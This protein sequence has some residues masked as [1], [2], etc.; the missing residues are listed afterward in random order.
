MVRGDGTPRLELIFPYSANE[1]GCKPWG[2]D[3]TKPFCPQGYVSSQ[4]G[5]VRAAS[6]WFA[7]QIAAIKVAVADELAADVDQHKKI[8]RLTPVETLARAFSRPRSIS[9]SLLCKKSRT[10]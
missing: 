2:D 1:G 5:I 7:E 6:Q 3:M 4:E 9:E 10:S 8:Q